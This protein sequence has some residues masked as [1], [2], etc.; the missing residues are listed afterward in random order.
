MVFPF[1]FP[2]QV[3]AHS[4]AAP[5]PAARHAAENRPQRALVESHS[6]V[7]FGCFLWYYG[8]FKGVRYFLE[9]TRKTSLSNFC[10]I[11][12]KSTVCGMV[13]KGPGHF[14]NIQ[15]SSYLTPSIFLIIV[16]S[17]SFTF[18]PPPPQQPAVPSGWLRESR[19]RGALSE[20]LFL[21]GRWWVLPHKNHFT[22]KTPKVG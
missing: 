14:L 16:T 13:S 21:K 3:P 12:C 20:A 22:T 11:V 5:P 19:A 10:S 1:L 6:R 2:R 4:P 9:R 15:L 7:L 8:S 17:S 18:F